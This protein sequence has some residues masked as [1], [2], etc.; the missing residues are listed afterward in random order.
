MKTLLAFLLFI[1][2]ASSVLSQTTSSDVII[3]PGDVIESED[4]TISWT[5]CENLIEPVNESDMG[6]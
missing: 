1:L 6:L 3:T 5:I 2:L 4:G